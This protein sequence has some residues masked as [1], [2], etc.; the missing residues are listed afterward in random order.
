MQL[1]MKVKKTI[2]YYPAL[3]WLFVVVLCGRDKD[4]ATSAFL[5]RSIKL[6]VER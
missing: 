1:R 5:K 6:Q 2:L 3:A 4:K